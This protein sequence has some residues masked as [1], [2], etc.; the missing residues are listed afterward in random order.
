MTVFP[1]G[2]SFDRTER[3][4]PGAHARNSQLLGSQ[5][6]KPVPEHCMEAFV[7]YISFCGVGK[8]KPR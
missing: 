3:V 8:M 6:T 5:L 7:E 1:V 4:L 2:T